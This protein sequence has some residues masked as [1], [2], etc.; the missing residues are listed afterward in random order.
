L[1]P[2]AFEGLVQR[3]SREAGF[4]KVEVT[5]RSGDGGIDGIGV[6][7][8]NL[9]LIP[10]SIPMQAV[11]RQRE[12]QRSSRFRGGRMA[13]DIWSNQLRNFL[14]SPAIGM[15]SLAGKRGVAELA[16]LSFHTKSGSSRPRQA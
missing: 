12:R 2:A 15:P 10:G 9:L 8:V 11:S 4:L 14:D 3:L 5:G 1:T 6:L 7:W 13:I 16:H